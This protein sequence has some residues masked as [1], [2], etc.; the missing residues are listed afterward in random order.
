MTVILLI[1]HKGLMQP[2]LNALA[3]V[4]ARVL[5]AAA[6]GVHL[7]DVLGRSYTLPL[8][9]VRSCEVCL[10]TH[11]YESG[12]RMTDDSQ[13]RCYIE[14]CRSFSRVF[15]EKALSTRVS[16]SSSM[17]EIPATFLIAI[18]GRDRC[19]VDQNTSC[20]S[21]CGPDPSRLGHLRAEITVLVAG[22]V[23]SVE[24]R[25]SNGTLLLSR[26]LKT[27]ASQ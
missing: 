21:W 18:I 7:E 4:P 27:P 16:T 14:H 20:R 6:N 19:L 25:L 23:S 10:T 17:P 9:C 15:R 3:S 11:F 1:I 8:E 13:L 22:R 26:Y 2:L 5:T 12:S 24:D